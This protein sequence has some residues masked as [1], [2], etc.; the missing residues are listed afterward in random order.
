LLSKITQISEFPTF[1]EIRKA[2]SSTFPSINNLKIQEKLTF[3]ASQQLQ[4][5]S[6][7][8]LKQPLHTS[9]VDFLRKSTEKLENL[10]SHYW[11]QFLVLEEAIAKTERLRSNF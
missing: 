6:K 4:D 9:E 7:S 2:P 1:E 11:Q 10:R 8:E 5:I 3:L